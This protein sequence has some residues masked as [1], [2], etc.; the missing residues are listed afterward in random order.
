MRVLGRTGVRVCGVSLAAAVAFTVPDLVLAASRSIG[1]SAG[2]AGA[3]RVHRQRPV[4]P[5]F[6]HSGIVVLGEESEPQVII[7]QAPAPAPVASERTEPAVSKTYVPSRWVDG[8]Y[9]V[10]VLEHGHWVESKP[11]AKR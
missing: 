11:A 9:G 4:S 7:I 6:R 10:Q 2:K 8:G 3:A 5:P 1:R